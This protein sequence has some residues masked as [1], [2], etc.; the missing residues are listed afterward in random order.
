MKGIAEEVGV[1][2]ALVERF[3]SFYYSKVRK[4][5]SELEYPRIYLEGLGTF[6]I[7]KAKLD[8][9]INRNKD[10]LGNLEKMTFKGY[11]KHVP[12]KEKLQKMEK[13]LDELNAMIEEKIKWKQDKLKGK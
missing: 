5:L 11:E 12:V 10:I 13:C 6:S 1:H 4:S 9:T 7:R 8:K 2:P 3:I